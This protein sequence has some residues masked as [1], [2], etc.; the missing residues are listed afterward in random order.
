MAKVYKYFFFSREQINEKNEILGRRD[1]EFKPGYVV[2]NGNRKPI[3]QITSNKEYMNRYVDVDL[4]AEGYEED[5]VYI[6]PE[7]IFKQRG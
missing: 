4:I 6:K 3:T 7:A 5:F 2:I 1:K